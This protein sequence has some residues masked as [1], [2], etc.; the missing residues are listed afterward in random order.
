MDTDRS[1]DV[2]EVL[3]GQAGKEHEKMKQRVPFGSW[4]SPVTT[5]LA[6]G[7]TGI[8]QIALDGEDVYWVESRPKEQGRSVLMVRSVDGTV[9]EVL[10]P[11]FNVRTR[12]HEYGGGAYVVSGGTVFF[13]DFD[14]QRLFEFAPGSPPRPITPDAPLRYADGVLD[15]W[16]AR[17]IAVRED[18]RGEGTE[19]ENT[20]VAIDLAVGGEGIVLVSG[21]DFVSSPRLSP[22]G[23]RLAWLS[24]NHPNMPWDGTELWVAGL[25]D[26]GSLVHPE[27]VAGG[28]KESV[29]QPEWS[30]DG[31]LH[32]VSDR[33]G[34]WNLYRQ[35]D[36]VIEPLCN[37]E[38]EF[39]QPHW[40]FGGSRYAFLSPE[41]IACAYIERG[42]SRLAVLDVV[43][44]KLEPID[45]PYTLIAEVRAAGDRVFLHCAS[46]EIPASL[47]VLDLATG[48]RETLVRSTEA[49]IEP[50]YLSL[51]RV[52]EFPTEGGLTAHGF[53]YPPA[54][55]DF[56]GPEGERPP[57]IVVCHG[58]PTGA[59]FAA[60]RPVIQYWTSRGVAILDVN[61]GGSTGYGRAY[62]E[63]LKGRWGEVDVD[64]CVNGA[65][66]LVEQGEVDGEKLAIWG[67]S[68]GGFTTL[69]ALAFRDVFHVGASYYGV[70]DLEALAQQTHKFESR[71]LDGLVGPYP[72]RKDLYQARSAVHHAEDLSCP[73]IFFQGLKDPVVPPAQAERMVEILREKGLPVAYVAFED[74]YHGFRRSEN[75]GR[76]LRAQL[77][78]FGRIFGFEPADG[79]EPIEIANL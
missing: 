54:N 68:A 5:D 56:E 76:A 4:K 79:R 46:P 62:R 17:I 37:R 59:S 78:F 48:R 25:E 58:G 74:E 53:F 24:W 45:L 65:L 3:G 28:E 49:G 60:F 16:R 18:H 9:S 41:R 70:S 11:S 8:G 10:P 39:G 75:M 34:W 31:L 67:G 38:A 69:A 26:D 30:E 1:P 12:V 71:Y 27:L 6:S 57:L 33:T 77:T 51:P 55:R 15:P 2:E 7:S 73:M 42:I 63:R 32:F 52:L 29:G 22:D 40:V 47:V 13:S 21:S 23:R 66:Y 14:S 43:T 20:I 61:Y 64:D 50:G 36:E 72:Q 35:G 19:P 44:G